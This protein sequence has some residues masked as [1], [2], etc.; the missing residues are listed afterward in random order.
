MYPRIYKRKSGWKVK[1]DL[2]ELDCYSFW[3]ALRFWWIERC[4]WFMDD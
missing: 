4:L 3:E 2:G 1:T